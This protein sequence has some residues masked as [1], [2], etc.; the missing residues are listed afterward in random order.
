MTHID[1][2][3]APED[4]QN[5]NAALLVCF[6]AEVEA[7]SA[8]EHHGRLVALAQC[9]NTDEVLM[10]LRQGARVVRGEE[11]EWHP[12]WARIAGA[13]MAE[14]AL[15]AVAVVLVGVER[16]EGDR[17]REFAVLNAFTARGEEFEDAQDALRLAPAAAWDHLRAAGL[18][19]EMG[20]DWW[21]DP[22]RDLAEG[23]N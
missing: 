9:L 14:A 16:Y 7:A 6:C 21:C 18:D 17:R 2:L 4:F 20:G 3:R 11:P 15:R 23:A 12:A 10:A 1:G 22:L 19:P 13:E 5:S 8:A